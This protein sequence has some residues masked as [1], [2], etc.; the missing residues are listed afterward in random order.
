[1]SLLAEITYYLSS[2]LSSMLTKGPSTSTSLVP[3]W[4]GRIPDTSPNTSV[5]LY[6]SGGAPP[7]YT[8]RQS[9]SLDPAYRRP[10]VQVMTRSTS[11]AE[12]RSLA[13]SIYAV[14]SSVSNMTIATSSTLTTRYISITPN[15]DPADIGRDAADRAMISTNYSI[16]REPTV[17]ST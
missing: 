3:I 5:G 14:L 2:Q 6:E 7:L 9:T 17:V 16:E 13:E 8:L 1:M 10:S 12:A 11:Y 15:Q 4:L